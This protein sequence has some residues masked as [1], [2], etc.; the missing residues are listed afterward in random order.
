MVVSRDRCQSLC[1]TEHFVQKLPDAI[2]HKSTGKSISNEFFFLSVIISESKFA[3][4]DDR[5]DHTFK[6]EYFNV[7]DSSVSNTDLRILE[8]LYILKFNPSININR[9]AVQLYI[10]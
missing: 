9:S 8:S 1:R 10:A 4:V 7:L 6:Y 3:N 5:E 2:I